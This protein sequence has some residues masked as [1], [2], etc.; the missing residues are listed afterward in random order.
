[1]CQEISAKML[2][3]V[4]RCCIPG[5]RA[6]PKFKKYAEHN[7]CGAMW[8]Y[9]EHCLTFRKPTGDWWK[10]QGKVPFED[11]QGEM[12]NLYRQCSGT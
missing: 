10:Q 6:F 4:E 9:F 7:D 5:G 1:M 11:V 2:E 12:A 8:S 3:L